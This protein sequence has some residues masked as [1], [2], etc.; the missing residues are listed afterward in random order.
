MSHI[1]NGRY[2]AQ[3]AIDRAKLGDHE[4]AA[5]C[6]ANAAHYA[7]LEIE[8]VERDRA[9]RAAREARETRDHFATMA[10]RGGGRNRH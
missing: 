10:W 3:Q 2:W 9:Y 5:A 8:R 6:H 4:G 1:E 7:A